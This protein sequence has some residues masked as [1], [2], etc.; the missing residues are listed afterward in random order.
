MAVRPYSEIV[1]RDVEWLWL[2]RF[3]L[4][5]LAVLDGDPGLGKS[6]LLVDWCAR[7]SR[8]RDWPDGARNAEPGNSIL[9]SAE[10]CPEQTIRR[11]LQDA[12]ADLRRVYLITEPE[13]KARGISFPSGIEEL[14]SALSASDARLLVIDP[15]MAFLDPRVSPQND[16]SVRQALGPVA[17]LAR[18]HRCA[19]ILSRHPNK[20]V[21]LRALYRGS[22]SIAIAG[23]GRSGWFVAADPSDDT[24]RVLAQTKNNLAEPQPSLAYRMRPTPEGGATVEWLGRTLWTA[25]DLSAGPPPTRPREKAKDFMLAALANGPRRAGE[26]YDAAHRLGLSSSTLGRA[27][28]ELGVL[29][30]SFRVDGKPT[31]YWFLPDHKIPPHLIPDEEDLEKYLRPIREDYLWGDDA[32]KADD[33]AT[34]PRHAEELHEEEKE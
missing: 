27:R 19:V 29:T 2:W 26:I 33:G 4:G 31:Y 20:R 22:G 13:W 12:D 9:L 7:L 8:G 30:Q 16:Q 6:F 34:T 17:Q 28:G 24:V 25:D 32:A 21:G 5:G 15:L 14:N 1:P 18:L 10:D 11:R 3:A 23:L